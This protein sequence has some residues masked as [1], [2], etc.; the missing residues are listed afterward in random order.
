[1]A[2]APFRYS[3]VTASR[4]SSASASASRFPADFDARA[5]YCL[6]TCARCPL[7]SARQWPWTLAR[8][9]TQTPSS[10]P[11]ELQPCNM[12]SVEESPMRL[13]NADQQA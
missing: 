12:R 9:P 5:A 11:Y 7:R 3:A 2:L 6:L 10:R 13:G 8:W 1:M 4:P